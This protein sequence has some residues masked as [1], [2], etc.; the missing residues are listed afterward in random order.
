MRAIQTV[1]FTLAMLVITIQSIRHVY[2]RFLE[3]R[4]SVLDKYDQTET[5]KAIQNADSLEALLKLY[6]PAR[7]VVDQLDEQMK[8]GE[9]G[10]TKDERD[11]FREKF[12]DEHKKEYDCASE[13]G[14][15][16]RQ[17]EERSKEI[18]E[19]RVFWLFGLT[20]GIIGTLFLSFKWSWFGMALVI[21]GVIEMI[22]WTAPSLSFGGCPLEYDRLL[23][24][25]LVFTLITL[26]IVMVWWGLTAKTRRSEMAG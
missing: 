20:L 15:A 25:K 24:N 26:L 13:L 17:W 21:P 19:L 1:L 12:N 10:K 4:T 23:I 11:L 7:K 2:V 9:I 18:Y 22:W 6:D 14:Y 8:K 3:P 5:K 16:I